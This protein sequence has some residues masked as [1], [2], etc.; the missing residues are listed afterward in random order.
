[1]DTIVFD[2][3]EYTKASA[4]AK[5]FRYTSDYV[6]QLCR[7]KKVNARLV[8]RTWF[9]N[10]DSVDGYRLKKKQ[11]AE[12]EHSA[13]LDIDNKT[14]LVRLSVPPVLKSKTAQLI[15]NTT[16]A[17]SSIKLKVSYDRD[18]ENLIPSLIKKQLPKPRTIRI[19]QADASKIRVLNSTKHQT[20]FK[21]E[22]LPEVSLSG[23][24]VIGDYP[25]VE[26]QEV[27][28]EDDSSENLLKNKDIS[29]RP[30]DD[31]VSKVVITNDESKSVAPKITKT[32][33]HGALL[34]ELKKQST[35]PLSELSHSKKANLPFRKV[36]ES[37]NFTPQVVLAAET[38]P[39]PA[40][41]RFLPL[42]ATFAAIITLLIIWSLSSVAYTSQ[43]LSESKFIFE[44][45]NLYQILELE[46]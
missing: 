30:E 33:S 17:G 42:F 26:L 29:V 3:I 8:G 27:E 28:A 2:G 1:M 10:I 7:S 25:E 22:E 14:R 34:N 32:Q 20:S 12:A 13:D 44:V 21:A 36:L 16:R 45:S 37:T 11:K 15:S 40:W 5:K 19:E 24:L 6:G 43:D 9:V 31:T 41:V 35:K 23:K 18:E 39:S 4:V 46:I 38:L